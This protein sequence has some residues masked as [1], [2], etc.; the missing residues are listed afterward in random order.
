ML[1][2]FCESF[3]NHIHMGIEHHGLGPGAVTMTDPK[4]SCIVH[5]GGHS[6]VIQKF[7]KNKTPGPFVQAGTRRDGQPFDQIQK[8]P[9]VNIV[10]HGSTFRKSFESD[11]F[12]YHDSNL[13]SRP[14]LIDGALRWSFRVDG[15]IHFE[16]YLKK[17]DKLYLVIRLLETGLG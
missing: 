7:L 17:F 9:P 15:L 11:T 10:C 12:S 4:V 6:V 14:F 8:H 5:P 16:G 3:L 2:R 13:S 1:K